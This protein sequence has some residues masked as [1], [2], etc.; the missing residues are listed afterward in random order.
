MVTLFDQTIP[1]CAGV[2]FHTATAE[3]ASLAGEPLGAG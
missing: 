3:R 2:A 1:T